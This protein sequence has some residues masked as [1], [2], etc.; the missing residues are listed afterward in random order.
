MESVSFD[1]VSNL[2][3]T[4]YSSIWIDWYSGMHATRAFL[5]VRLSDECAGYSHSTNL[6]IIPIATGNLEDHD[7]LD[8][9]AWPIWRIDLIHE[10]LHEWQKKKPCIP[11]AEAEILH[12]R[13]GT[14][15]CGD[16]HGPDFFQA[17]LEKAPYFSL[18]AEELIARVR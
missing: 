11:S 16:G 6:M 14:S 4:I 7:I 12:A 3:R 13:H 9:N 18:T 10:M 5:D 2:V 17:I 15:C 8:A 1:A